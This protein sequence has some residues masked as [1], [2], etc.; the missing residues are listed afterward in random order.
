MG[1]RDGSVRRARGFKI[2]CSLVHVC[3]LKAF[4]TNS[5]V[6]GVI[7]LFITMMIINTT[8]CPFDGATLKNSSENCFSSILTTTLLC[9]EW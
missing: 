7:M 9:P 6:N 1:S 2:Q 3:R 4:L 5:K 8:F